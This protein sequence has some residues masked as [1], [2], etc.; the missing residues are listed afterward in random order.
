MLD[1]ERQ[2]GLQT[3][4]RSD[5]R[6]RNGIQRHPSRP[7]PSGVKPKSSHPCVETHFARI[8]AWGGPFSAGR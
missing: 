1:E 2:T 3:I 5:G 7:Y 8:R 6:S 4:R